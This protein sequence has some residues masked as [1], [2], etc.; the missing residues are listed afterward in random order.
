[1]KGKGSR[2]GEGRGKKMKG[3]AKRFGLEMVLERSKSY[4][5]C[6]IIMIIEGA[7]AVGLLPFLDII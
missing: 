6:I 2:K 3:K 7:I 5:F 4:G 1:M